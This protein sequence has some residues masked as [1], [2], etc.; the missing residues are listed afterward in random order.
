MSAAATAGGSALPSSRQGDFPLPRIASLKLAAPRGTE[1][2]RI[3]C[4][5]QSCALRRPLPHR[6]PQSRHQSLG[7][8]GR[9]S[10]PPP[11]ADP[12]PRW[13][14]N[15]RLM[16]VQQGLLNK[17]FSRRASPRPPLRRRRASPGRPRA[18]GRCSTPPPWRQPGRPRP[19]ASPRMS[20]ATL[21]RFSRLPRE[22][23]QSRMLR[24]RPR[25]RET[26]ARSPQAGTAPAALAGGRKGGA[27]RAGSPAL[28]AGKQPRR[29][30]ER[31]PRL[32]RRRAATP[33]LLRRRSRA[34]R[35]STEKGRS[36]Q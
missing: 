18:T 36:P 8:I 26:A 31:T 30:R 1:G 10:Q 24:G 22:A 9:L 3:G 20:Q 33:P 23:Q 32:R 6:R 4:L 12:A 21:P 2:P 17:G 19:L 11:E 13:D 27:G 29:P 15:L 14:S 5:P 28:R 7:Q 16:A 34:R 25:R 35:G